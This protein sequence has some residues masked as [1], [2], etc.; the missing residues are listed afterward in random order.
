MPIERGFFVDDIQRD[1]NSE[2]YYSAILKTSATTEHL[3]YM[4]LYFEKGFS[5]KLMYEE[6]WTIG[7]FVK[8]AMAMKIINQKQLALLKSFRDLRNLVVHQRSFLDR[9][10][11][12]KTHKKSLVKLLADMCAYIGESRI[13][14]NRELEKE[15]SKIHSSFAKREEKFFRNFLKK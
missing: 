1:I 10:V 8:W 14:S 4:K 13:V 15:Y 5:L 6:N 12:N 9:I 7:K 11:S 3:L 2:N